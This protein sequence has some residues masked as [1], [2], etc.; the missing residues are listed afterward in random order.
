ML[1]PKSIAEGIGRLAAKNEGLSLAVDESERPRGLVLRIDGRLDSNNS[2]DFREFA[3]E[4][5]REAHAFGGLVIDLS[6]VGYIS[7]TGVGAL[8]FLLADAKRH[9][10]PFY[11]QGMS[12]HTK[13]VFDVLGF[14][15]FFSCVDANGDRQP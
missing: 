11:L 13:S 1:Q 5:L 10:I 14:T 15:A 8:T 6:K 3:S 2:G 7:S 4:V 12:E 9:E